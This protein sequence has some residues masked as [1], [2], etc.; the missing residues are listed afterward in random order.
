MEHSRWKIA[1]MATAAAVASSVVLAGC[2]AGNSDSGSGGGGKGDKPLLGYSQPF[3][4]PFQVAEQKGVMEEYEKRG[5]KYLPATNADRD[6]G[7]QIADINTLIN[8]GAK[9]LVISVA[10][11]DAIVPAIKVAN[12]KNVPIV[13]IDLAPA[14]GKVAMIVR[15]DNVEMGKKA[16]QEMGKR[17]KSGQSVLSLD[18]DQVTANGRDRTKGFDDC[19]KEHFPDVKVR[20]IST[21]WDPAKAAS[22][23]ETTFNQDSSLAGVYVQS[24]AVFFP[25]ILDTL[26]GIGKLKPAGDPGHIAVVGIDATPLSLDAIRQGYVDASVSQPLLDYVKYGVDYLVKAIDGESFTE[27]KTDHNSTIGRYQGILADLLPTPVVTKDNVD[28]KNLWGN[29]PFAVSSFAGA[30]EK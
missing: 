4:D 5:Y 23:I 18:G 28:D 17:V 13:A 12:E 1:T 8:Q 9:G 29:A 30:G 21:E 25:T 15:A 16:C 10:D 27:G 24:D 20:H 3:T 26:K 2:G 19:M 14:G 7:Q 6:A 11:A 22:G